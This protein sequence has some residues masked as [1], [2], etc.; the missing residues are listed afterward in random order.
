MSNGPRGRIV[1]VVLFQQI[2]NALSGLEARSLYN[3]AFGDVKINKGRVLVDDSV[4]SNNGDMPKIMATVVRIA[5]QFMSENPDALLIFQGYTDGK[6]HVSGQNQRNILYQRVIE[7]HWDA[8]NLCFEIY[9]VIGNRQVEYVPRGCFDAI[10]IVTKLSI[11]L[12]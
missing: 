2:P 7:S 8:L 9:G 12:P 4:R 3:L 10:L 5:R 1:K 6:V 11:N